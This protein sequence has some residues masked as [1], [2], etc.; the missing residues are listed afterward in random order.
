[1]HREPEF[2]SLIKFYLTSA[3]CM[4]L[5][6]VHGSL[7]VVTPIREW[8]S[9]IGSPLTGPGRM[10]DPLAHAHLT[11]IGGVII[12]AMGAIYYLGA[13]ISGHAIYS[14]KMLEHSFWWTTLGM[15]GTYG[16]F[17]FFGIT[18]GHLLLTQPEQ[19]E[20]VHVYYGPTLSVAGTAMSTGFLIFFI[21][22]VLTVR[23]RPGRHEAS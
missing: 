18:E 8:L 17:M 5:G 3:A 22:L 19:I 4:F 23:N 1:M 15:F 9:A 7:Q 2:K 10:I 12:F 16:S 11:V 20:A 13:H 21:N 6:A 14:R